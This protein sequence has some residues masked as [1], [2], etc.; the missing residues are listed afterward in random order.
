M[1]HPTVNTLK[2]YSET[3]EFTHETVPQKLLNLHDTKPGVWG[4]I[5]VIS[6]QLDYIIPEE[7]VH[8]TLSPERT[9]W[10]KPGQPHKVALR[11]PVC[12]KVEFFRAAPDYST[13]L[14][15]DTA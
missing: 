12:F 10:I 15:N 2:K 5:V 4:R 8:I 13:R 9:A 14:P 1:Q 11:G 7:A 6:G 3:P